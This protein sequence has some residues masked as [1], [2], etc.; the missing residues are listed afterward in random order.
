MT[1]EIEKVIDRIVQMPHDFHTLKNKSPLTLL[2]EWGY[3]DFHEQITVDEI[4]EMLK[5][6]PHLIS[7]WLQWSDDQRSIPT[8]YFT[9]GEEWCFI[10]HSPY[11]KDFEEIN[12]KDEFF[13]CASFIKLQVEQI[14]K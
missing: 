8:T 3:Y 2:E 13:A 10:G 14:R 5:R 4:T 1:T 7:E 11:E 6:K 12:T 9:K